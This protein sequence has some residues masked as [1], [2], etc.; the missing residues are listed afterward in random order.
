MNL[1]ILGNNWILQVAAMALTALFLPR[2]KVTSIFGPVLAVFALAAINTFYW[3]VDLFFFIP[4]GLNLDVLILVA[5]N[6]I[7]FWLVIKFVPGIEIEGLLPAL[8]APL[9]FTFFSILL[10]YIS[11]IIPWNKIFLLLEQL[12]SSLRTYFQGFQQEQAN[13]LLIQYFL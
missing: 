5:I 11:P 10:T 6:G 3:D 8:V 4:R 1:A 2:L 12:F 13:S 9:F 7:I